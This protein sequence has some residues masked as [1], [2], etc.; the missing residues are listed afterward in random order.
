M[1]IA[2]PWSRGGWVNSQLFEH[3]STLQFLEQFVQRKYNKQMRE[4]NISAWRRA[5]S[6]DLTSCFRQYDGKRPALPFLN[7]DKYV[8]MI[9]RARY[10]E[11]PSNY[12]SL[13]ASEIA[14]ANTDPR[15]S[16]L[17]ASQ[18]PGVRQ[19]CA[20]PYEPY[21]DG[22]LNRDGRKFDLHMR[23]GN[24]FGERAAG[25][26]FNVYLYGTRETTASTA[27]AQSH[28][29]MVSA[30]Y[31]VK[32]NDALHESFELSK[33]TNGKYDIAI[34]GPN[35]FFREFTG[36]HNDPEV[37]AACSYERDGSGDKL[38]GN[39]ELSLTHK[40]GDQAYTVQII[41][42]SYHAKPITKNI[43]PGTS[44]GTTILDLSQQHGWY[45]F[46]VKVA[47]ANGFQQ[48]YA[49]HVESGRPSYT[50]P[51]MGEAL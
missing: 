26:P 50:D 23:V 40:G 34:H 8:E 30:T 31:A 39:V 6:G 36:D 5:I 49:G 37:E 43:T 44:K 47:G 4:T 27:P 11:V 7:R 28:P 42:N 9:Q 45:D 46:T 14:R 32:P 48:R 41:D 33:F 25:F 16:K 29:R 3:T 20:L 17:I 2:S 35:G 38:S 21:A 24:V 19:A 13:T 22:H 12:K 18:E 51:G 10:K 1:I 15:G